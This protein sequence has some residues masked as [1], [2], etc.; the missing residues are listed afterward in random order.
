MNRRILIQVTTP[1]AIIGLLLFATCL[2]SAWYID[3]LQTNMSKLLSQNV[4]SLQAAQAL[5]NRVRQLRFDSFVNFM[6]PTRQ[7][8]RNRIHEDHIG[9]EE[10]IQSARAAAY[11]PQEQALVAKIQVSYGQYLQELEEMKQQMKDVPGFSELET[12]AASAAQGKDAILYYQ[13]QVVYE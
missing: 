13:D 12:S 2:G 7:A 4:T 3:R 9:F 6:D 10:A 11:T 1:G 8:R 5:E